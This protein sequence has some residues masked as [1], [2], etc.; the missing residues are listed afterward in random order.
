MRTWSAVG[1][2]VRPCGVVEALAL[3]RAREHPH[4]PPTGE[5]E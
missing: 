3:E 5:G 4:R 2:V 1:R